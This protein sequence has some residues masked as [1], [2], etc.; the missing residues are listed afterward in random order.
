MFYSILIKMSCRLLTCC[1]V[2]G[3]LLIGCSPKAGAPI[4]KRLKNRDVEL[5]TSKGTIR[6]RLYE[7]T[8]L[9]RD[10]FIRLVRSGFYDGIQF[11]RVIQDFMIQAGDPKSRKAAD[12][13]K[14]GSGG[15]AYTVPAEIRPQYFHRKGV[16]AAAR[17]GDNVNPERAS[18]GS[19]FYI[20]QGRVFTDQSLD[21]VEIHRLNGRKLPAAHRAVYKTIGGA[22]HLD[23]AYTIYGEVISGLEV[24]D[25]IAA[26]KTS[27]RTGGDRPLEP[28]VIKKA[29][30]VRR[31]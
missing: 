15:P 3:A 28:V 13:A 16:L 21:S 27:G 22:P 1:L 14:L 31:P 26:V 11:H 9:H 24:V 5:Q 8:P 20:V 7:E 29:R 10:N 12:T 30:L 2:L 17:M 25:S 19:Q 6:L 23:Q 18:S 4:P